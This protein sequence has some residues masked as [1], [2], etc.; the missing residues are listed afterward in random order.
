MTLPDL[1]HGWAMAGATLGAEQGSIPCLSGQ[2]MVLGLNALL[3]PELKTS[4]LPPQRLVLNG[5]Y[6]LHCKCS[7]HNSQELANTPFT[8]IVYSYSE[9][10]LTRS[11]LERGSGSYLPSSATSL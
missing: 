1:P 10:C 2:L 8:S 6:R 9:L 4:P 5:D 11:S 7:I 3:E